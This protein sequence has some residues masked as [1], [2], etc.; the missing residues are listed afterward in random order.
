[1]VNYPI[2]DTDGDSINPHAI[3][4]NATS[5]LETSGATLSAITDDWWIH[6]QS[7]DA[8]YLRKAEY[9][10]TTSSPFTAPSIEYNY[11]DVNYTV[12]TNQEVMLSST[13]K[14]EHWSNHTLELISEGSNGGFGTSGAIDT[15]TVG[16]IRRRVRRNS[17]GQIIDP[18]G[19]CTYQGNCAIDKMPGSYNPYFDTSGDVNANIYHMIGKLPLTCSGFM[20]SLVKL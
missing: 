20:T 4:L 11:L 17:G 2:S 10:T 18:T 13:F 6:T 7:V 9:N 14:G 16:Y 5:G 1:M 15:S 8:M 3:T 12:Q 19:V